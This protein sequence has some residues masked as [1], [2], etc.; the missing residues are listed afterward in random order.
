[1]DVNVIPR[2][3]LANPMSPFLGKGKMYPL[4]HLSIGLW[5]YTALQCRGSM[6][7]N[8]LVFHTPGGISSSPAAFLFLIFLSNEWISSWVNDPSQMSNCLLRILMI[9]SWVTSGRFPSKFSK[10]CFQ[11]NVYSILLIVAFSLVLAV[12]FL[13]LTWFIFCHAF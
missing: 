3:F 11:S 12:P 8:F 1:M 7:S 9:G 5:L 10:C 4:I 6:S 2:E 13:L